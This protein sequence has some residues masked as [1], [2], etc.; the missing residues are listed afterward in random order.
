MDGVV[1][2]HNEPEAPAA[3]VTFCQLLCE[4]FRR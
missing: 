3:L 4:G 1:M 2:L